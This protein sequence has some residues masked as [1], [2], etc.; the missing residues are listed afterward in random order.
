MEQNIAENILKALSGQ[1]GDKEWGSLGR[2]I[3]V[4]GVGGGGC[5]AVSYMYS[6]GIE[7]CLFVVCNT[8]LKTLERCEVPTQ[9]RI[10]NG[11]G[12]GTRPE[13]G[14]EYALQNADRIKE[15]LVDENTKMVF[16]TAS[17]GGGTGTGAAP[18]VAEICKQAGIL[19]IGVVTLP[20]ATEG[21]YARLKALDGLDAMRMSVDSLIVIDNN[22]LYDHYGSLSVWEAFHK[23]DEV[24]STAVEGILGIIEK[25]GYINVD[26]NDVQTMMRDSGMALMGRGCGRGESRVDD[27]IREATDSPLLNNY[28]LKKATKVLVNVTCSASN[29]GLRMDELSLLENKIDEYLGITENYKKGIVFDDDPEFGDKIDIT[30]VATGID[31]MGAVPEDYYSEE[32]EM[33]GDTID[34]GTTIS[35][36]GADM[37]DMI[38][39]KTQS[40]HHSL[41]GIIARVKTEVAKL[42]NSFEDEEV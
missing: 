18:V 28:D 25:T 3:K 8:D 33:I 27:A 15:A 10:G 37:A 19:T 39:D 6:K 7:G 16:V 41:K 2:M 29:Q 24:L 14:R 13:L 42:Y 32:R 30:I 20:F 5:N 21:K 4:V 23:A 1:D 36:V 38:E 12:A 35:D 26:L 31:M 22:K 40:E 17:L 34:V 9:I 11:L